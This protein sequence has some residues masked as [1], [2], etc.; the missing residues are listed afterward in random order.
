L[1]CL[2]NDYNY[3][4]FVDSSDLVVWG[5]KGMQDL[6][7]RIVREMT[8]STSRSDSSTP[9]ESL[10]GV[11]ISAPDREAG[12]PKSGD[13][14]ARNPKNHSDQWLVAEQYFADNFESV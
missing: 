5:S 1:D 13:M 9:N 10:D 4:D 12:S 3:L 6:G 11:S 8:H 2:P 7:L 14:I